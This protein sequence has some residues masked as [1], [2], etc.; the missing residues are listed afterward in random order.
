[1]FPAETG[2]GLAEFETLRSACVALAT[3]MLTVAELLLVLVSRDVVVT[4]SV[5]VMMVPAGVP[6]FTVTT[7]VKVLIDPGA[8]LGLVQPVAKEVQVHPAGAPP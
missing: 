2:F 5:S 4:V 3:G 7:T 1:M 6:A 8:K